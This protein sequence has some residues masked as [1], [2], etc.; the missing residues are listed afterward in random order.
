M[1]RILFIADTHFGDSGISKY[2]AGI[3]DVKVRDDMLLSFW[4]DNVHRSDDVYILGDLIS[5]AHKPFEWYLKRLPGHLHLIEGNHDYDLVRSRNAM[6]YFE[7]VDQIKFVRDVDSDGHGAILCHYPIA[8][9][10]G[11]R[12]GVNHV[13]GHIHGQPGSADVA[14]FMKDK[15][16]KGFGVAINCGATPIP[17]PPMEFEEWLKRSIADNSGT[18]IS[19][20]L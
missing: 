8:E 10:N 3:D 17:T 16:E 7:S 15:S 6:K 13:Y 19:T 9:W 12:K 5:H 2:Q 20:L 4:N 18:D 11:Y 14:Q 1:G